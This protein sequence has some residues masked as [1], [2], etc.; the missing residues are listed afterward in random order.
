MKIGLTNGTQYNEYLFTKNGWQLQPEILTIDYM[1]N[2][3]PEYGRIRGIN[4]GESGYYNKYRY[5][6]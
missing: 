2:A 6:Y 3:I 4:S 1:K 5:G